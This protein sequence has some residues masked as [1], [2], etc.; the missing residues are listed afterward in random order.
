MLAPTS[1][2]GTLSVASAGEKTFRNAL[3]TLET[4]CRETP[5]SLATS[6]MVILFT[7]SLTPIVTAHVYGIITFGTCKRV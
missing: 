5:A 2:L 6:A 4:V 1:Y 3:S 7:L